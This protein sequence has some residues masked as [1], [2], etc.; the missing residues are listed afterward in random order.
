MRRAAWW[1]EALVAGGRDAGVDALLELILNSFKQELDV[2]NDPDVLEI[3]RASSA[4]NI[5]LVV[6][7]VQRNLSLDDYEPPPQAVAF[8][9]EL[10]H[11]N[12]PVAQLARAY[13]V[14]EIALWRWAAAEVRKRVPPEHLADAIEGMS[15]AAL[16]TGDVLTT[17]MTERY[18]VEREHWVR[19][20]DAVRRATVGEL[21]EGKP[22][23]TAAA[24]A[25]LR[26]E[27][28]QEHQAFV[29]WSDG[30][31][32]VAEDAAAAVGG[33]RALLVRLHEGLV[34]GWC[35][36]GAVDPGFAPSGVSLGIGTPG[37]GVE[38]FRASYEQAME[39]RR[40]A[41]LVG[42]GTP[43]HYS[44][45]ALLALL[46]KDMDQARVFARRKLGP[47]IRDDESMR[48]LSDTLLATLE[49]QG[50]LRRA[51]RRLGVH[52]NTVA[53]RLRNVHELLPDASEENPAEMLAALLI[54]RAMRNGT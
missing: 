24:S 36:A 51:S 22:V 7:I 3:A 35:P 37:K 30:H 43:T 29:A 2:L 12:I 20:A 48:R 8:A 32:G 6:E 18:A 38:G 19:S 39:A 10:V 21:L 50:S 23:D 1:R 41:Q 53:K 33:Q 40:V 31:E 15:E 16:V 11:A 44:D 42:S 26:Y 54:L 46:T 34:V 47:L 4:A 5:A 13:R 14:A 28:R 25:R 27:L 52:E 49:E 17:I 9:R 45:V